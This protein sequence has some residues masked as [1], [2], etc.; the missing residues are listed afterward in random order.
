MVLL[1]LKKKKKTQTFIFILKSFFSFIQQ[2]AQVCP[3]DSS[4]VETTPA[5]V[6]YN[7]G[8]DKHLFV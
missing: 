7:V 2:I 8:R 6:T 1:S 5:L 3:G 4:K